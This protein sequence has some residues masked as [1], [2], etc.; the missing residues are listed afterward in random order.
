MQPIQFVKGA[1]LYTVEFPL[2]ADQD[3]AFAHLTAW[4]LVCSEMA[5]AEFPAFELIQAFPPF[6]FTM[7]RARPR[8]VADD[9]CLEWVALAA[10]VDPIAG[11]AGYDR[12]LPDAATNAE[13]SGDNRVALKHAFARFEEAACS[14]STECRQGPEIRR[15][16]ESYCILNA[17]TSGVEQMIT[18][19]N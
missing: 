2:Q 17:S 11:K 1:S 5:K 9:R 13:Q 16:C 4:L 18:V 19:V 6:N 8:S 10:K 3:S 7:R 14:G 15:M 12:I